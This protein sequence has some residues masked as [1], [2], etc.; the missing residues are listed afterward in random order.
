[1][2]LNDKYNDIA[3]PNELFKFM[4]EYIN[5]GYLGKN[6]V[7][8]QFDDGNFYDAWYENYVLESPS[9]VL[10][11]KIGNCW[12]QVELEREWFLKHNYEIK[13]IYEMV[14]LDYDNPYPTHTFLVYKDEKNNWNWFEN[15]DFNN[16]GIH[17]FSS[18]EDLLKYQYNK[19]VDL[20]KKF[21]ISKEELNEVI[22][23]EYM[24]PEIHITAEEFLGH[25]INSKNINMRSKSI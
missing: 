16:R 25:V 9:E 6:G 23:T 24:K 13:T 4:Q 20:L 10:E 7:I 21:D 17:T 1:M 11:N 14:K 15:A 19:Y 12:D 22:I 18:L 2:A 5:Y 8:Y 3:N